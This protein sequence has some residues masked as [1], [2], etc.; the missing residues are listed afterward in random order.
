MA[1]GISTRGRYALRVMGDLAAWEGE[2]DWI[3][4][5]DISRRQAISRKYLEQVMSSL[6]KAQL[7]VSQRG[8]GGGYRLKRSPQDYTLG[9]IIRA[10]EGGSLAP[11]ACLDCAKTELCPRSS[12]CPTLGIWEELGTVISTFLDSKHLSDLPSDREYTQG[13]THTNPAAEGVCK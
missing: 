5:G 11:V 6:H 7:V 4:L 2:H 9:E 10:A 1:T 13:F 12:F 3:S 8:K